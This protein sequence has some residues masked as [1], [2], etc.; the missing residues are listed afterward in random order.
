ME[1]LKC[2]G[3]KIGIGTIIYLIGGWSVTM[4]VMLIF[5]AIDYITGVLKGIYKKEVS[6]KVGTKGLIKK[7]SYILA[8]IIGASLDKIILEHSLKTPLSIFNIPLSFRDIIAFSIVG[9]EGIS[10]AE[11]LA[12][13]NILVPSSVKKFLKQLKQNEDEKL[14]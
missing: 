7:V 8:I 3:L 1:L 4:E 12:E 11:N 9:N 6:S 10:I 13:I 5:I 2:W 14:D